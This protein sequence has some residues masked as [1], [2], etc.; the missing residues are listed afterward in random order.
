MVLGQAVLEAVFA[1][2]RCA[3]D[4]KGGQGVDVGFAGGVGALRAGL[5]GGP[6][7]RSRGGG[8]IGRCSGGFLSL[9]LPS[10][11]FAGVG[12]RMRALGTVF[13]AVGA[14][15]GFAAEGQEV[16]AVAP[17]VLAVRADVDVWVADHAGKG[18]RVVG[19]GLRG[20]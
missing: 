11:P 15:A 13:E 20:C 5:E 2:A 1:V 7:G 4:A 14:F 6:T 18:W 3:A 12:T 19:G 10:L 16:E 9:S 8:R 17:G